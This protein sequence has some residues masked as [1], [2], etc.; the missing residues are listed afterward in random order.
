[1]AIGDLDGKGRGDILLLDE[2]SG[3]GARLGWLT[4][5]FVDFHSLRTRLGEPC[6]A[7]SG[8]C[9][10]LLLAEITGDG[11]LDAVTTRTYTDSEGIER[12]VIYVA[13]GTGSSSAPMGV[14]TPCT[15]GGDASTGIVFDGGTLVGPSITSYTDNQTGLGNLIL[16]KGRTAARLRSMEAG[17]GA[18]GF[19]YLVRASS[20]STP[21]AILSDLGSLV[22]TI[23]HG[24]TNGVLSTLKSG[25]T[26][27]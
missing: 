4:S 16:A 22:P 26:R 6:V 11:H 1:V 23:T 10:G 19:L 5:T 12:A 27:R 9:S 20:S 15:L 2:G 8:A 25:G 24:S 14:L 21:T 3:S 13:E 17:T 18:G 7:A